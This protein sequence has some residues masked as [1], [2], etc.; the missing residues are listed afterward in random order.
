[1][2]QQQIHKTQPIYNKPRVLVVNEDPTLTDLLRD[3]EG[4]VL[5]EFVWCENSDE[6]LLKASAEEFN[7]LIL[8]VKAGMEKK[9]I[10]LAE[11]IQKLPHKRN[12]P[13]AFLID[14]KGEQ[15]SSADVACSMCVRSPLSLDKL[16][17][18]LSNLLS[19]ERFNA[20]IVSESPQCTAK[21]AH[22]LG[23]ANINAKFTL[24]PQR[25]MDFLY[26][27]DPEVFLVDTE[28]FSYNPVD[29]CSRVANSRWKDMATVL[30]SSKGKEIDEELVQKCE[31]V[32]HIAVSPQI[33]DAL[34]TVKAIAKEMQ[35][36]RKSVERDQLT[37]LPLRDKLYTKYVPQ[38]SEN[39][40]LTNLSLAW[41][42]IHKL[43]SINEKAGHVVGDRVL[44]TVSAF[45]TQRLYLVPSLVCRWNDD[46][47]VVA[48]KSDRD[49]VNSLIRNAVLDFTLI[50]IPDCEQPVKLI[51]G[52]AHYPDD[53]TAIDNLLDV[54]HWRLHSAKREPDGVC[55]K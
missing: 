27:L 7:A 17:T 54:A 31:A 15:I 1:M 32:A 16:A 48:I 8:Q 40:A 35:E 26:D 22:M 52:V 36:K 45:L 6:S 23:Q 39:R 50:S 13:I 10:A 51:A 24:H 41:I 12:L 14:E 21:L 29:L 37:G 47:F 18:S 20:L 42:D 28:M 46:E 30:F 3:F 9:A 33:D 2:V 34:K 25:Y 49:E 38:L 55:F 53:G 11:K 4:C 5:S 43:A 44:L 19:L